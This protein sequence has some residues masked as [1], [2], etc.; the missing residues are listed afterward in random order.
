MK[1]F[2]VS[3]LYLS[4]ISA[5][6]SQDRQRPCRVPVWKGDGYCDDVNNV[7]SCEYDG[8]DCCGTNVNTAFCSTCACLD[9]N[10]Q[11]TTQA[12]TPAPTTA[13]PTG[14]SDCATVPSWMKTAMSAVT[15]LE[16][17]I[18]GQ[19]APEPIPWQAHMRQGSQQA[20]TFFCGGTILDS[21]TILTAA[22]CYFGQDLTATNFYI[23]AGA[24]HVQDSDAQVSF[25]DSITIHESYNS[26]SPDNDV[27]ILKL[28]T[29]LTFNAKVKPACLPAATLTP[30]GVAVASGWGLTGQSPNVETLDLMYVAKPVILNTQCTSPNTSWGTGQIT[31]NM[32]CAG[33][34]DG[35]ESTCSGDSGGPLI[36]AG[37]NDQAT[38]IGTTSFGPASG[39]GTKGF[40]AVY[41]YTIPF[42]DWIT[43]KMGTAS[44]Y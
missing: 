24:T 17:I 29:P 31:S 23:A 30:S 28:K 41:A 11:A 39:C 16:R 38:L 40:P 8:G 2:L 37:A 22:H 10:Q 19:K 12:P 6:P 5:L 33:D 36:V 25:V 42:L 21:T 18:N 35:G 13:T 7:A 9:P 1:V 20:F 15:G 43:P 32:I 34:A 14:T 3:V 4:T 44:G 26:N 27:A